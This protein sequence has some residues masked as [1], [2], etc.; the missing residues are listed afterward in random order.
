MAKYS[1]SQE[2]RFCHTTKVNPCGMRIFDDVA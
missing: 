1:A 2:G